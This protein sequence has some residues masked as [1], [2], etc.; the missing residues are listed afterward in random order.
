MGLKGGNEAKVILSRGGGSKN[1]DIRTN[2]QPCIED[3]PF[4]LD[5]NGCQNVDCSYRSCCL[6]YA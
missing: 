3:G 4:A 5:A 1:M 2:I 6:K